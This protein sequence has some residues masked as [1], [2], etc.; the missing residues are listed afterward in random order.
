VIKFGF[1]LIEVS[2]QTGFSVIDLSC[3]YQRGCNSRD[4]NAGVEK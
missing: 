4:F 2:F 3:S 1:C